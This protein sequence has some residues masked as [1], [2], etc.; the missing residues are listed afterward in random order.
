MVGLVHEV[1]S[2]VTKFKPGD[3]VFTYGDWF[4]KGHF[5]NGLVEYAICDEAYS[6]NVPMHLNDHDVATLPVNISASAIGLFDT[7]CGLGIPA[8]WTAGAKTFD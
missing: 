4:E 1:G 7:K 3:C 2:E 5:Q 6:V 8:P